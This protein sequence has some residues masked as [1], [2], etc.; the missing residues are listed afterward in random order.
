MKVAFLTPLTPVRS[1]IASY[2]AMI[3][4][5][6]ASLCEVTAVVDQAEIGFGE[7]PVV[8][9]AD[10]L[11]RR[12][13]FDRVVCQIGNNPYHETF[14][15]FALENPSIVVL[16]DMVLHHLLVEMTL[17]RGDADGYIEAMRRN[18]GEAGARLARSRAAGLHGEIANFLYPASLELAQKSLHVIVINEFAAGRLRELGVRTPISL[19]GHPHVSTAV[20]PDS[21]LKLRARHG[22][23]PAVRVVGMFGFVTAAKRPHIVFQALARARETRPDLSLLIVGEPGPGTD[24]EA[25]AES[26]RVPRHCW[27]ATGYVADEDFDRY[28]AAVDVVVNLRYPSAGETS[29]PL[30]HILAAGVPVAV[31]DY[32]SFSS[33]PDAVVAKIRLGE[34]EVEE[35]AQFLVSPLE[36]HPAEEQRRWVS[37][38]CSPALIAAQYMKVLE[39]PDTGNWS[40]SSSTSTAALPVV[41]DLEMEVATHDEMF[42]VR[43]RNHGG[44]V[45]RST[46]FGTPG[47]RLVAKGF[48]GES[49]IFSDWIELPGDLLPGSTAEILV[50]RRG[51]G[52]LELYDALQGIP[53][54]GFE[55]SRLP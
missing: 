13:E 41:P 10:F 3:L 52:R 33:L 32:A 16:H 48:R 49:E 25:I 39:A 40:E 26:C 2:S 50:P 1:G 35:L 51:A 11:P 54:V 5:E 17:A 34:R 36:R 15:R 53:F 18:H 29:G 24:L 30:I 28:L 43:I 37:E 12:D 20:E 44:S 6:L 8:R 4:R 55:R 27:Q 31:S 38:R 21:R 47:Y 42:E 45:V 7:V 14:Y 9:F 46:T 22:F 19:T 23:G